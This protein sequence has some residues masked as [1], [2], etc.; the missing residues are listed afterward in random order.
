MKIIDYKETITPDTALPEYYTNFYP[1]ARLA[2]FD[3]ETT[4]FAAR[5]TTLYLIGVLWY[6]QDTIH[7]RQW[8]NEDGRNETDL[9]LAF[10]EFC[11]DFTHLVHFN[12][13]GFDLPYLKQK[14]EMLKIPFQTSETLEQ[15]DIFKEIRSYKNIFALDNMKQVS[16]ERFLGIHRKDTYNGKELINVYQRYVARP[17]EEKEHFLLLHNHDDLLG[18]PG[19]SKILNYK[20]FFENTVIETVQTKIENDRFILQFTVPAAA[21]LPKRISISRDDIYLN[22]L[23]QTGTLYIPVISGTLK[24]FF[25][26]YR[27]YYYLPKED[28]AVHKSVAAY[29]ETDN[30]MKAAKNTCY[31]KKTD[32]FIVCTDKDFPEAFQT[33][34]SDKTRYQTLD[35]IASASTEMQK[36]YI[37]NTLRLF[38]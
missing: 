15:I 6:E 27:N 23:E 34:I 12:G 28:M 24:H 5:N 1:E 2:F 29:V 25:S 4:G 10:D 36:H 35:S 14:A 20:A 17:D 3:I 38:L 7:I 18:M 37:Q 33:D 30:K 21:E 31:I 22:A 26:D 13:L 11:K 8:F 9:I 16:I 32:C 19:I